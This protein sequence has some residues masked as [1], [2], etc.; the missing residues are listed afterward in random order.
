MPDI[1]LPAQKIYRLSEVAALFGVCSGTVRQWVRRG[2][3]R[4]FLTLG[5]H[6]RFLRQDI[7]A[8]V[9]QHHQGPDI[10][11]TSGQVLACR[12]RAGHNDPV[13]SW[14]KTPNGKVRH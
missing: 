3:L 2:K 6:M 5:G 13:R 4:F 7:E 9:L 8:F 11:D 10:G 1:N 14:E 12:N